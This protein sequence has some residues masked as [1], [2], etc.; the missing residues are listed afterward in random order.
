VSS[1][2]M[3]RT[4]IEAVL[5]NRIPGALTFRP[6]IEPETISF[7]IPELDQRLIGIMRG[8]LAEICG[9]SSSGRT[10]L[11]LS[12]MREVTQRGECCALVDASSAFDPYSAAANGVKLKNLFVVRCAAPH[13]KLTPLDKA[14][15]AVD[16]I[17]SDG[18]FALVVL[19]LGDIRPQLAQR[20]PLHHWYR[21]R[22]AVEL[23]NSSLVVIEQHPFAK[24]CAAQVI[25]LQSCNSEWATARNQAGGPKLL[26]GIRYIAEIT[27]SRVA[28]S[29]RKPP[30]HAGTPFRVATS[31]AG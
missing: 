29:Q 9:P 10:T 2:S 25:T 31:W 18:G 26:T 30:G 1:A 7:G 19:D 8:C 14:L 4:Q 21:F 22:R 28:F 27:R 6:A 11:M 12:V 5:A 20:I 23:T 17:V 3:V 13:P 15:K 16:W 24:S